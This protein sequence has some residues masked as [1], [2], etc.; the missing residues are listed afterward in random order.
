MIRFIEVLNET[1]FNPRMERTSTPKFRLGEVWINK[2]YVVSISEARGYKALLREGSLPADLDDNHSF[3]TI[4]V[5]NGRITESHV[6]VGS[7]TV[8]ATRFGS[9]T[10]TLLKG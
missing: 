6:V 1:N 7:P 2:S 5:N 4:V 9:D 3:T 10:Q 8:V